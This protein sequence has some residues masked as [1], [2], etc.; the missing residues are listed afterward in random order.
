MP[1]IRQRKGNP[2]P[3]E[4][5]QITIL[6]CDVVGS[7]ALSERLDPED[8]LRVMRAYHD[9]CHKHVARMGGYLSR[10][11]GDGILAYFGYPAAHEDD[12]HRA[13]HAALSIVSESAIATRVATSWVYLSVT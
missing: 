7:T 10:T 8:V 1:E 13:L 12:P 5:R 11:V 9:A 4:R 6:F 3:E 2:Q